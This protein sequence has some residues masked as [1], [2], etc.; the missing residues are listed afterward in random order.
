MTVKVTGHCDRISVNGVTIHVTVDFVDAIDSDG[1]DNT[2]I[3]RAGSPK[4]AN[5][6]PTIWFGKADLHQRRIWW[7]AN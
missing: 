4:I 3:Y 2:V 1:V 5:S 7:N 6:G